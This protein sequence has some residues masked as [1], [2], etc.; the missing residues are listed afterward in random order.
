MTRHL[1][2]AR[3]AVA[4]YQPGPF[5]ENMEAAFR[6]YVTHHPEMVPDRDELESMVAAFMD[7]LPR[8]RGNVRRRLS[9]LK[10]L[11]LLVLGLGGAYTF[12]FLYFNRKRYDLSEGL[13]FGG[14]VVLS[15]VLMILPMV[16][17]RRKKE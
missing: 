2:A 1:D 11:F 8:V 3:R 14:L 16:F 17:S 5:R 7:S 10:L 13:V 12:L 15:F 9:T 6:Y 4:L